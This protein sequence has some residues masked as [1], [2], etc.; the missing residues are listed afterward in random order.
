MASPAASAT[1]PPPSPPSPAQ[2]YPGQPVNQE[3][4]FWRRRLSERRERPASWWNRLVYVTTATSLYPLRVPP[5]TLA[6]TPASSLATAGF[7]TQK[8]QRSSASTSIIAPA[9]SNSP[10]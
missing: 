7:S 1:R 10:Q 6:P 3:P 2:P 8:E 5:N 4:V 9:L